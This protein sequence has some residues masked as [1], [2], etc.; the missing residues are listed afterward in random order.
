MEETQQATKEYSE[1]LV[2]NKAELADIY[3]LR[4]MPL[5]RR[6]QLPMK[7]WPPASRAA[8][9]NGSESPRRGEKLVDAP[10][11][12]ALDRTA[13]AACAQIN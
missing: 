2:K 1:R 8:R 10:W 7:K 5:K 3:S 13:T 11:D 4:E 12:V 9:H 6:T